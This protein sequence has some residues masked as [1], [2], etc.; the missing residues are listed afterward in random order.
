MAR[1]PTTLEQERARLA[2]GA[3]EPGYLE[4]REELFAGQ[5]TELAKRLLPAVSHAL[6][7]EA[8]SEVAEEWLNEA[9]QALR[10]AVPELPADAESSPEFQSALKKMRAELG[11]SLSKDLI[12]PTATEI[13]EHAQELAQLLLGNWFAILEHIQ[14]DDSREAI[15][16][17]VN[18]IPQA[19]DQSELYEGVEGFAVPKSQLTVHFLDYISSLAHAGPVMELAPDRFL[20]FKGA[21]RFLVRSREAAE[22]LLKGGEKK[23]TAPSF[24]ILDQLLNPFLKSSPAL[25]GRAKSSEPVLIE[26][27]LERDVAIVAAFEAAGKASAPFEISRSAIE[28]AD[29]IFQE[30]REKLS[31]ELAKYT[32]LEVKQI[33]RPRM[34]TRM[35]V[36]NQQIPVMR[37]MRVEAKILTREGT[38]DSLRRVTVKATGYALSRV[39]RSD[40]PENFNPGAVERFVRGS[41]EG[42]EVFAISVQAARQALERTESLG[43]G[44][45]FRAKLRGG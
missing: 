26:P 33:A 17:T 44:E 10:A 11:Q 2:A 19:V 30:P 15:S 41:R 29:L 24:D 28:H 23:E 3:A 12:V 45:E 36:R 14:A 9:S 18:G 25:F 13:E 7:Q 34:L 38:L 35:I 5:V 31:A 8:T 27:T 20:V 32:V 42:S 43:I 21:E 1:E 37:R 40:V 39:K 16:L 4:R 22:R 6:T